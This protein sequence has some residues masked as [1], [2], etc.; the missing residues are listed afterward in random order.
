M[1]ECSFEV[2]NLGRGGHLRGRLAG[3]TKLEVECRRSRGDHPTWVLWVMS[4]DVRDVEALGREGVE[5]GGLEK[6]SEMC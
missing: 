1:S 3:R 4:R 2:G 5:I 6:K